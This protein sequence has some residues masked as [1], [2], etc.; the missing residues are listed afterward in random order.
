MKPER[1]ALADVPDEVYARLVGDS[2]FASRGFL[3]LWR[4]R[5]GRPVVWVAV[6]DGAMAA[7]LPGVEYGRAP[8]L[9]FASL[10]DGCYGGLFVDPALEA[11]RPEVARV[12]LAAVARRR[13]ARSDIFDYYATLPSHDGFAVGQGEAR[14]VRIA[15]PDWRP[16][17]PKLQSQIRKARREG[18]HVEPFDWDRHHEGFLDLA[19]R[20]YAHHGL[21]P[22]YP[23]GFYR[24]LA[25]LARRDARVQWL[26]CEREGRPA[27][28]HIYFVERAVLQAWQSYFDRAFSYLKPNAYIRFTLCRELSERGVEWLNLGATPTGAAGLAYYKRR[29]G[30]RRVSFDRYRR[31]EGLGR[32]ADRE[33]LADAL[34]SL[35]G[36]RPRRHPV[37]GL[38]TPTV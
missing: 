14:L 23:A 4:A 30:G 37:P 22:R 36:T 5:G 2:F 13:Y 7:L 3:E 31:T 20:T 25:A 16:T 6:A 19:A 34:R 1:V 10:P 8:Y 28:S 15:S 21:A 9:R 32:L 35:R 33:A 27:C 38:R 18:I 12:L 11:E 17:D 29:W 24:A 26:W